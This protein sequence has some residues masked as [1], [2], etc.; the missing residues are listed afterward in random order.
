MNLRYVNL[1]LMKFMI[2]AVDGLD[3]TSSLLR[4]EE[5]LL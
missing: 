2:S 5:A 1:F 3:N 4:E